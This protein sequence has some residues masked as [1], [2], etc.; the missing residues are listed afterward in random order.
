MLVSISMF[1]DQHP[2]HN[3][4]INLTMLHTAGKEPRPLA[5]KYK[6]EEGPKE[7]DYIIKCFASPLNMD[8]SPWTDLFADACAWMN[9]N[10]SEQGYL[11][12]SYNRS[13]GD[14]AVIYCINWSNDSAEFFK[15]EERPAECCTIF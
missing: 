11:V 9:K 2:N 13:E 1:E 4:S 5:D 10:G 7:P 3:N 15:S 6:N 14:Q 12:T 8:K